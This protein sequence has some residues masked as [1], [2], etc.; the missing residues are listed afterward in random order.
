MKLETG[1]LVKIDNIVQLLMNHIFYLV[2]IT[3]VK[4]HGLDWLCIIVMKTKEKLKEK[5]V[6]K[7]LKL[8]IIFK[9]L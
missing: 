2:T 4:L 3:L 8:K 9:I 1:I 7:G 6:K 5:N